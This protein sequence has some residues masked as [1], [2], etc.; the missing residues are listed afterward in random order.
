[1]RKAECGMRNSRGD[2]SISSSIVESSSI[3]D[4]DQSNSAFRIPHSAFERVRIRIQCALA[5]PKLFS[6]NLPKVNCRS[7]HRD[8]AGE[9]GFCDWRKT[10]ANLEQTKTSSL[11]A[12]QLTS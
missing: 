10:G 6:I 2:C 1:M 7:R 5:F 12:R 3:P 8:D 9:P 4:A 11:R